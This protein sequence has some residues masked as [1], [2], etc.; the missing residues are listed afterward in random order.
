MV[1]KRLMHEHHANITSMF[2]AARQFGVGYPGGVDVLVHFRIVLEKIARAG[3]IGE[4]LAILDI[5]FKNMF[6]S[7][8][9]KSIR[10]AIAEL[11]PQLSKWC[12][13]CHR[14]S[15]SVRLP[16]GA[17]VLCDRGAEQGD[18]L[19]PVYCAAVLSIVL[20]RA[21]LRLENDGISIAD[22]W[23]MDDGQLICQPHEVEQVM[24]TIDEE[25]A[26]V[27]AE[28]GRR[29]DAKTVCS[30][31]GSEEAKLQVDPS[32]RS[33]YI[34][35]SCVPTPDNFLEGHVLGINFND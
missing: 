14:R 34:L 22:V 12:S 5:N 30:L 31:L 18:P 6:P 16:S 33:E 10:E 25:A 23:Y 32:W 7:I 28:R 1:A 2:K 8:E 9:R 24:R 20:N 13:W 21:R 3:S 17:T 15:S 26:L 4:V 29:E 27:G 35:S 11:L 19:G